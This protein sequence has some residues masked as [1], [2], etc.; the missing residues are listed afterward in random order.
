MTSKT[1]YISDMDGTLL[2]TDSRISARSS[3]I[4][5]SLSRR[6]V[7]VTVATART[8]A[9][10]VPLLAGTTTIVPAVVMTGCAF[11]DRRDGHFTDTNLIP[12]HDVAATLEL[13]RRCGVHPFVYVMAEDG[14]TLDVYHACASLN[15]AEQSF[16][17]ERMHLS[18]KRFHLGTPA[19]ARALEHSMLFYAMGPSD[20]ILHA[21]AALRD[22]TECEVCCYPDI[23]NPEIQNLEIFPPGVS[24]AAAVLRL[25]ERTGAD[26]LMVFGDNLN[27]IPMFE[28]ADVAVAVGNALPEVKAAADVVIEPNYTD[29]VARYIAADAG[30]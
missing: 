29:S 27:D 25:K 14:R 7:A 16:Y 23:F 6:G 26:R 24:K 12:R 21:A 1:L 22:N 8:P 18:L 4:I 5:T 3:Q 15:K 2:S 13:C 17:E 28:V 10:V 9:T 20:S 30:Y 11:W 19:P